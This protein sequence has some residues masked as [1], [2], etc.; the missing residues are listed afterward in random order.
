MLS[1]WSPLTL[2]IN[3]YSVSTYDVHT[4]PM[5]AVSLTELLFLI[6]K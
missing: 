3:V 5:W 4:M 6:K 2:Y 1:L